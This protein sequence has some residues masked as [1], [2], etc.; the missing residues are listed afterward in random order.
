[1][2]GV[3]II[4]ESWLQPLELREVISTV[5]QD[6][7]DCTSWQLGDISETGETDPRIWEKYPGF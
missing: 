2:Q 5:S 3:Q 6:L 4:P 1:M 7:Y